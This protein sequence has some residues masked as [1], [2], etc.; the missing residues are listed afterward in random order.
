M[1]DT[2]LYCPICRGRLLSRE[3]S[4]DH[5][6]E[7]VADDKFYCPS[8]EMFV[9]PTVSPRHEGSEPP[10]RTDPQFN[11]GRTS[12]GGTNAGRSQRGD[13]SDEGATQWRRDPQETER[14]TWKEKPLRPP[15]H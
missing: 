12:Q 11:R 7:R 5:Q 9:E 6:P 3:S 2:P 10:D 1:T 15:Q 4:I 13:L 8:C 14:N